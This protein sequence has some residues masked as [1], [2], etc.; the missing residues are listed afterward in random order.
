MNAA[1]VTF[2]EK[3]VNKMPRCIT[4]AIGMATWPTF[5]NAVVSATNY[6]EMYKKLDEKFACLEKTVASNTDRITKMTSAPGG[7]RQKE[8]PVHSQMDRRS[9]MDCAGGANEKF[10]DP[11]LDT[12]V[13]KIIMGA[14]KVQATHEPSA[15]I[16]VFSSSDQLAAKSDRYVGLQKEK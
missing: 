8:N 11:N 13:A 16:D 5:N 7:P 4:D 2:S 1:S 10:K 6:A 14:Q 15:Q 9:K 3:E 12:R